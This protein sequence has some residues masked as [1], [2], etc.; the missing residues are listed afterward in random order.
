M[1][2]KFPDWSEWILNKNQESQQENLKKSNFT[3]I[4]S[5]ISFLKDVLSAT[6][7]EVSKKHTSSILEKAT[8]E[9]APHIKPKDCI[10]NNP[11][12]DGKHHWTC[13]DK[14]AAP[15]PS[16]SDLFD[17]HSK[18]QIS[19][20]EL[21]KGLMDPK[22][23][24]NFDFGELYRLNNK[25]KPYGGHGPLRHAQVRDLI[26]EHAGDVNSLDHFHQ[27]H[28]GNDA[29][30]G[31]MQA[32]GSNGTPHKYLDHTNRLFKIHGID[33]DLQDLV[34]P[35]K[36]KPY[37]ST[38]TT[39]TP[40]YSGKFSDSHKI[41]YDP[42]VNPLHRAVDDTFAPYVESVGDPDD[43]D[44]IERSREHENAV[45]NRGIEIFKKFK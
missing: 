43:P 19:S 14:N 16:I 42:S 4:V 29:L 26:R 37:P 45:I 15:K 21:H 22:F 11:Y 36:G 44:S 5:N 20:D 30:K 12:N 40:G 13:V 24:Q 18:G 2:N 3:R 35:G 34:N 7:H 9:S 39:P 6:R 38:Q 8:W 31:L 10:C 25:N 27:R 41:L 17:K 32:N 23:N 1:R 33:E 28:G